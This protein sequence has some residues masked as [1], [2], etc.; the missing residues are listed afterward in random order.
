M[1]S[2]LLALLA[3]GS[4]EADIGRVQQ[5]IFGDHGLVSA[6]ALPPLVPVA[7]LVEEQEGR[8]GRQR[9]QLAR[10]NAAVRAPYRVNLSGLAWQDGWLY[11]CVD[12]GGVWESLRA[13][14]D[15]S[16]ETSGL[17][18]AHEG[19]FLGCGEAAREQRSLVRPPLPGGTFSSCAL[20]LVRIESAEGKV[21]WREVS[22]EIVDEVPLRGRRPP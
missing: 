6:V 1:T 3:P 7:F 16:Q 17:F 8:V 5:R 13:S 10:L 15:R 21:W 22:M 11:L 19:F 2:I 20:A 4:V 14:L 9:Q 18:P 12:S